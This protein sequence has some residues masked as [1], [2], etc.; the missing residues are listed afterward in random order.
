MDSEV[1]MGALTD[2]IIVGMFWTSATDTL[3]LDKAIA[4][5]L[6]P[7]NGK[8]TIRAVNKTLGLSCLCVSDR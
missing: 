8:F 6:Y 3:D 4:F 7:G 5:F 2:K 1:R